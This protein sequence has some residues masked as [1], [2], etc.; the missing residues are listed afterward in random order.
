MAILI[1]PDCRDG[2]HTG[3]SGGLDDET[4]KPAPCPCDCHALC[5]APCPWGKS[6]TVTNMWQP[7]NTKLQQDVR[8]A[9]AVCLLPKGHEW[10]PAEPPAARRWHEAGYGLQPWTTTGGGAL[11]VPML[12]R[13]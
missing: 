7:D 8:P 12:D 6:T 4:G 10:D 2:K 9:E 13:G 1:N 3:C 5:L 11:A